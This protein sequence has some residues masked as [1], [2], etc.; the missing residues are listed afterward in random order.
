MK[1]YITKTLCLFSFICL[2]SCDDDYLSKFPETE[3]GAENFFNTEEDLATYAYSMYNFPD[4]D[5]YIAD[6]ATDNMNT[7]GSREIKTIMTTEA[8]ATTI[9]SGWNWSELRNINFFLE[10]IEKAD[11]TEEVRNHYIG[12]ARFFRAN[13]YMEKVKRYS[14]VPWYSQVLGTSSQDLYKASDDRTT[15]ITHIFEDY[16]FALENVMA[17]RP[18]G[19]VNK[20]VVAAYYSRNALHEGTFRKYHPELELTDTANQYLQM[21]AT[22]S[23]QIMDQG[24]YSIYNT[25][26][27]N[28]D[29]QDLFQSQDLT[30]NPEIIF[31]NTFQNNLKN[32]ADPQYMFGSYEPGPARDLLTAYLN[33]DGS[34][35]NA[36]TN[37]SFVEE[38]QNRDPRLSQTFA[39]PGWQL[40]Y[41]STYSP[42]N[43]LYVQEL[44]KNFTGYHQI[45]GFTNSPLQDIR[46]GVDVPVLRY[47]EVLLNYAEAKQELNT[48]TQTDLDQSINLLR[49]RVGLTPMTIATPTDPIQAARHPK[50]G[51]T[52]LLE[53]RRE[54]R[55]ELALEGRRLDDLNRWAAGKL[56]EK[57]PVGMYF[58]GLGKHDLTGDGIPDIVLIQ[59]T[60]A[61]PNPKEKNTLG[62][63]LVYYKVGTVGNIN[64]NVYLS[65]GT[66]G[67]IVANPE[68]GTFT[69]P[70]HYYRPIPASEIQLNSN[71]KQVFG[72]Q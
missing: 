2:M 64:A 21:A 24:G 20:W 41:T 53:I 59:E 27:P 18:T 28:S 52:L 65:Q 6:E 58:S 50:I 47:A 62:A 54:R 40:Y 1:K 66:S 16:Q 14:N 51:N 44:K 70:K 26:N 34:F 37:M 29:Y 71:L 23:K 4:D 39:Y 68:R 35:F 30:T 3:I 43:T 5:L 19:E 25:G 46:A 13:F 10:N 12:V 32:A 63:E 69:E 57:E 31:A 22:V 67:Y 11:V 36:N 48:I 17:T 42:G 56:L 49:N 55:V 72:W 60:D 61:V 8:N 38:F 9:T 15:V 7:T 33:A 45:K